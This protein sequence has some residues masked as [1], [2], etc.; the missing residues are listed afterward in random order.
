[1]SK[2][3]I[4]LKLNLNG[5]LAQYI[6]DLVETGFY[7]DESEVCNEI[8]RKAFCEDIN[9]RVNEIREKRKKEVPEQDDEEYDYGL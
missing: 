1:M 2:K 8:L 4:E 7:V 5:E 3:V 9:K 6:Y